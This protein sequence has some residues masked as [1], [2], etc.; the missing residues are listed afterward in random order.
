MDKEDSTMELLLRDLL[1]S[2]YHHEKKS[3]LRHHSGG[4][5]LVEIFV[6]RE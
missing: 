4:V 1:S 5:G 2:L 3:R 6:S